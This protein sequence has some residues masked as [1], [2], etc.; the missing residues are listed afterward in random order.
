MQIHRSAGKSGRE[1]GL[2]ASK[3]VCLENHLFLH[4]K[5]QE[6]DS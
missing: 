6:L 2:E 3:G 1:E 4:Q 5:N